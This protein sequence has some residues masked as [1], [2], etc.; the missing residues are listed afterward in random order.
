MNDLHIR[1]PFDKATAF[2]VL[3]PNTARY[4]LR[5]LNPPFLLRAR[6]TFPSNSFLHS[7]LTGNSFNRSTKTD[8]NENQ[9]RNSK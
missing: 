9:V 4:S 2:C 1:L 6:T 5:V 3:L 7:A 8:Q